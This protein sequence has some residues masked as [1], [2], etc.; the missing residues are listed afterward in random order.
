M[1][2]RARLRELRRSEFGQ[3]M[4]QWAPEETSK[5][6][7]ARSLNYLNEFEKDLYFYI[8]LMRLYPKKFKRLLW[9][10]GPFFDQFL[11]E[12]KRGLHKGSDYR[13]ISDWLNKNSQASAIIPDQ[14]SISILHC[15][16]RK[17]AQRQSNPG[18]C[19]KSAGAWRLQS[20]YSESNYRDA[21]NILLN[22]E[23]FED[24]FSKGAVIAVEIN[25]PSIKLFLNSN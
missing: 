12:L 20:F 8:N 7:V 23:D 25:N 18:S 17:Y 24:I 2:E 15:I 3:L 5:A 10:N 13:R 14:K 22:S 11:D 16:G 9:D 1:A 19:L 4:S 21:I 6:D